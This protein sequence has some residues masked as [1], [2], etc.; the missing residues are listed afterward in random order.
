MEDYSMG[1]ATT[2][3]L[4]PKETIGSA[5]VVADEGG[6]IAGLNLA[7][8]VFQKMDSS[9]ETII[10]IPDGSEVTKNDRVLEINGYLSSILTA[11]RTALNFLRKLSGVAT[12]TAKYV[13][14]ISHTSSRIVDT[15]K[16]TPG[17][18]A[19]EKYAVRMGGG[20]NHR[21]NLSDGILIKDNHVKTLKLE[22]LN[23]T[24]VIQK[25]KSNASHTIKVEVEV[26][27]VEQA[28]EAASAGADI[29]LL[30]NMSTEE[31][32]K[33]VESCPDRAVTEAS[34]GIN[35]ETVKSVAETGVNLISVGA[36]THSAPTLD[37]SLD[38]D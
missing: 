13:D 20:H 37:L 10:L 38:I 7:V 30:D 23:L 15:R 32:R 3:A 22:G 36:I 19:L 35:L 33:A 5:T 1:D 28:V 27:T 14:E 12:E 29:I 21:Q 9:L 18:R 11:E 25:A 17:Y 34:G 6:T 16:T 26:E 2:D 24:G 4:I 8:R 31:M